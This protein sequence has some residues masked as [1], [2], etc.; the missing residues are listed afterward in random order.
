MTKKTYKL[1]ND[2]CVF[3]LT[4]GRPTKIH[5]LK[6]LKKQGYTGK[7]FFIC[8]NEDSKLNKYI[9][10]YG[11][12]V[13]VFN[14]KEIAETFDE[15][16]NFKKDRKTIVYAR[17]FCFQAAKNLG[18]KYFL[19]LDDDYIHF[20][21]TLDKNGKYTCALCKDLNKIF[22]IFLDYFKKIPAKSIAMAQGGDIIGGGNS[23]TLRNGKIKRKAMNTFFCST[24]R[25]FQFVGRINEDVNTYTRRGAIGDIFL[26][27]TN[28]CITQIQT[29][30]NKGGMTETYINSGT[31]VKSF[32]SVM[33]CPSCVKI[34]AMGDKEKRIHHRINWDLAVPK[35]IQEKFKK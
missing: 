5:T 3:I 11:D 9:E 19:Q 2:F 30:K 34:A 6:S 35:I 33:F 20:R 31:Y 28:V 23:R 18:I 10:L 4:H 24:D 17:N 12:K 8:D 15:A 14:K 16:D 26:T 21:Y 27:L 7:I 22:A 29:Q 32:Y 25:P 1:P 13:I